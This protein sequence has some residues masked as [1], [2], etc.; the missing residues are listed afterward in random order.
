MPKIIFFNIPAHGHVNPS[1]PLVKELVRRGERVIYYCTETYR[2]KI[3]STGAEFRSYGAEYDFAPGQD[4][5]TPFRAMSLILEAGEGVIAKVIDPVRAEKPDYILYDSMC[6][7]GKQ[8]AH[9]IGVAAVCSC[10]IFL[11]H[12]K[13]LR[14]VPLDTRFQLQMTMGLPTLLASLWRYSRIALRLKRKY[15]VSSPF[16]ANFFANPGD[17]TLVYTSRYFQAGADKFDDS[18]KFVGPLIA[19][20]NDPH[21]PQTSEVFAVFETSEVLKKPLLYIS[22]GTL[23]NERVDF[24]RA[25]IEAF[26]DDRY[27]VIMSIGNKIDPVALGVIPSNFIVRPHVP[28]LEILQH[29]D[30]FITH[31]GMNSVSEGCWYGVPMIVLPQVGDQV[32]I[33]GRIAQL[34]AAEKLTDITPRAIRALAEKVLSNSNYKIQSEKIGQTLREA[35]GVSRAVEEIQDFVKGIYLT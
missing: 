33:A 12:S 25:C 30:L 11:V 27:N 26:N 29:A 21:D 2:A 34:G 1:I 31:G 9:I 23:F 20:R 6:V 5:V 32:V 10:S 28:Q 17:M 14:D 7:W 24:F 22:L 18:F 16:F 15:G 35:G 13:N 3:E 19:P 8:I 4:A